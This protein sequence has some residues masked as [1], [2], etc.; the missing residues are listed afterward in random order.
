MRIKNIKS[1]WNAK[2]KKS[3]KI[4][5]FYF[6]FNVQFN[7]FLSSTGTFTE[8][9]KRPKVNLRKTCTLTACQGEQ[10]I[11]ELTSIM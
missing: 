8:R 2:V 6:M 3:N 7:L 9:T 5:R 10:S 4:C 1:Q 11:N